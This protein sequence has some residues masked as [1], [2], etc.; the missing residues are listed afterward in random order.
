MTK[1]TCNSI[2][3]DKHVIDANPANQPNHDSMDTH[4]KFGKL[5]NLDTPATLTNPTADPV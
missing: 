3:G 4:P 5:T 1:N 2:T